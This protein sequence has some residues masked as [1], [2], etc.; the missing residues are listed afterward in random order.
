M[1]VTT[2]S[3]EIET[4][5]GMAGLIQSLEMHGCAGRL[6]QLVIRPESFYPLPDEPVNT[7]LTIALI[8]RCR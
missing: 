1:L 5:G 3:M 6:V 7:L 4:A 2:G 8:R